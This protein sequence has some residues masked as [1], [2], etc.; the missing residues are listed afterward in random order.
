MDLDFGFY[1]LNLKLNH[2]FSDK[3]RLFLS[4]YRGADKY[5]ASTTINDTYESTSFGAGIKWGI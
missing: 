5:G 2:K 4:A 1:D 3:D